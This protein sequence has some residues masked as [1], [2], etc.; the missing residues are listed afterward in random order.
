VASLLRHGSNRQF[1][2]R[3]GRDVAAPQ[4]ICVW[5]RLTQSAKIKGGR[6]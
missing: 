5:A 2:G 6:E 1:D 3:R 4:L